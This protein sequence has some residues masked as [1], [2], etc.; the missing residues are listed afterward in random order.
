MAFVL[1]LDAVMGY[2][3]LGA[4]NDTW[5]DLDNCK[6]V[7]I[8]L[9]RASDDVSTRGGAGF[10]QQVATLRE[11]E[12]TF[13]MV[14]DTADAGFIAFSDAFFNTADQVIGIF[15]ADGALATIGTTGL[16]ADFMVSDFSI[17]EA[18]E[19]A[20]KVD[21]TCMITYSAFTPVW[22]TVV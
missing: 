16:K 8:S 2:D 18:L 3:V 10:R 9:S 5:V 7:A 21:V 15:C 1:G 20:M 12:I 11:G 17:S 19:E 22:F 14:Y 6:D 4:S 13:Q